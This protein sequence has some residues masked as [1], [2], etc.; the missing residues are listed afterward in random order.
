[1]SLLRIHNIIRCTA[2]NHCKS[3][4][5]DDDGNNNCRLVSN[6]AGEEE[7]EEEGLGIGPVNRTTTPIASSPRDVHCI[8][9]RSNPSRHT[10]MESY[11]AGHHPDQSPREVPLERTIELWQRNFYYAV[12]FDSRFVRHGP[13]ALASGPVNRPTIYVRIWECGRTNERTSCRDSRE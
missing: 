2:T 4:F 11:W 9:F 7:P 6:T 8:A 3:V 10:I 1:M 13:P 5:G 12:H